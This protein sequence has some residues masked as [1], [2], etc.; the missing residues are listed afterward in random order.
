M[1]INDNDYSC[2][3]TAVERFYQSHGVH[4]T[5]LVINSL[6]HGHTH[7]YTHTRTHT[8]NDPHRINF[9]KLGTHQ[10]LAGAPGLNKTTPIERILWLHV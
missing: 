4:I 2:H 1:P 6:G 5:P 9:K 8:N 3:V 7:T 10:P